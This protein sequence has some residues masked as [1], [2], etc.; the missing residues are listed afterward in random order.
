MFDREMWIDFCGLVMSLE[1]NK[2]TRRSN[3]I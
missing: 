3:K 1:T 2:R